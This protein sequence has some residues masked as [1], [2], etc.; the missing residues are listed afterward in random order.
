MNEQLRQLMLEAGYA[1]PELAGRAN[2]LAKLIINECADIAMREDHDLAECIKRHFVI[3]DNIKA[4]SD[5]NAGDGGYSIG[6]QE[7]Y[8]EFVKGRNQS[9]GKM[10]IREL[11]EQATTYIE[12]TSNSGEG[13]IFDKEK[14]AELIVKECIEHL[15]GNVAVPNIEHSRT[16]TKCIR[17]IKEHFGV[18]E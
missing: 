8:D 15:E 7:K 6:T 2:K 11:A 1:A 18:T 10:R 13:W 17:S 16:K 9:L 3:M 14:F 12:P 4:G 5:I